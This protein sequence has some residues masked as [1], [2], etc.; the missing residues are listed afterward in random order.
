MEI[1][2]TGMDNNYLFTQGLKMTVSSGNLRSFT[3]RIL[4]LLPAWLP[5][6]RTE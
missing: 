5:N 2:T 1:P 6:V 4:F 3:F